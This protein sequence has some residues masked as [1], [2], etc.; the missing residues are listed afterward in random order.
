MRRKIVVTLFAVGILGA[1][2]MLA[3]RSGADPSYQWVSINFPGAKLTE[4]E[5]INPGGQIVG[6]YADSSGHQHGFLLSGGKFSSFDYP[7]SVMTNAFGINPG[8]AIVG[9][10]DDGKGN[11]PASIHGF[12]LSA[13]TFSEVQFPGYL[14][15]IAKGISPDGDIWGCNHNTDFMASMHGFVR[16]REGYTAIDVPAS[17]NNGA[18]PDGKMVVGLYTDM[19][20]GL[21]HGYVIDDGVFEPFD[22]PNSTLTQAWDVNPLREIVGNYRDIEGKVHGFVRTDSEF[23]TLDYPEAVATQARGI[24]P[25]GSI[26]GYYRDAAGK[27]HGFALMRAE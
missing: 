9:D 5:G 22:A 21:T 27:T 19:G 8:G 20:T 15:T 10:W 6:L 26:V 16:T 25:H 11:G 23:T 24:N 18:T 1:A 2:A 17:M 12:L 13:G 7:G 4:A 3:V 14:G